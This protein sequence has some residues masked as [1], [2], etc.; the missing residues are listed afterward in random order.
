MQNKLTWGCTAYYGGHVTKGHKTVL[1]EL[2]KT[3]LKH[4]KMGFGLAYVLD[5][6]AQNAMSNLV[7]GYPTDPHDCIPNAL[8]VGRLVAKPKPEHLQQDI[9]RHLD[10]T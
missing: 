9:V 2:I 4:P 3:Q 7:T 5:C 6:M 1:N 10:L 8:C